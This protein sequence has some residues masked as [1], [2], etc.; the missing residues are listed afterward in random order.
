MPLNAQ[1]AIEPGNFPD[2]PRDDLNTFSRNDF[3][4][5]KSGMYWVR[6][7][8][9]PDSYRDALNQTSFEREKFYDALGHKG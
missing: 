5:I 9:L 4:K 6:T 2:C 1:T 3:S 8:D 7:S